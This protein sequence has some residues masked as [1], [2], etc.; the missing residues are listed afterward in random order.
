MVSKA[1]ERQE[2]INCLH[3]KDEAK[4]QQNYLFF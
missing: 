4:R 1:L 3:K 2:I